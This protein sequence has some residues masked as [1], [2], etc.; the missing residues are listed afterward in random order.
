M[1]R[2][3]P[4]SLL[5]VAIFAIAPAHKLDL[6]LPNAVDLVLVGRV[7]DDIAACA[8]ALVPSSTKRARQQPAVAQRIWLNACT[9]IQGVAARPGS[10]SR[11]HIMLKWLRT[12]HTHTQST[13]PHTH[14][15]AKIGGALWLN[16]RQRTTTR[17]VLESPSPQGEASI[18]RTTGA[19]SAR[20]GA[21]RHPLN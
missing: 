19:A 12:E 13:R 16:G 6:R 3:R 20:V 18:V 1:L 21:K 11:R 7:A 2:C 15:R 10:C 14:M 9:G 4:A 5:D 17:M 8:V